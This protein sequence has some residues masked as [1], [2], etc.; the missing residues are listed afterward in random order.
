MLTKLL[1]KE[2]GL[3]KESI[4][5]QWGNQVFITNSS[6]Q[7]FIKINELKI[8]IEYPNILDVV[9]QDIMNNKFIYE[10]MLKSS[11]TIS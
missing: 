2:K 5:L 11:Y 6:G 9:S 3:I 10:N 4:K 7:T 1:A 8:D